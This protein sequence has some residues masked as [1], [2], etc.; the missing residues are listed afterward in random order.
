[1][2]TPARIFKV[3]VLAI[4]VKVLY[5][6]KEVWTDR[7]CVPDEYSGKRGMYALQS[8]CQDIKKE[9][10]FYLIGRTCC[11]ESMAR[12]LQSFTHWE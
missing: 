8:R 12:D 9:K 1:M 5:V 10:E 2:M 3:E 4:S 11:F 6:Q 7:L